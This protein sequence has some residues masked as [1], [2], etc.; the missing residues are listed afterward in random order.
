MVGYSA[1]NHPDMVDPW[2]CNSCSLL[3]HNTVCEGGKTYPRLGAPLPLWAGPQ[4]PSVCSVCYE[5]HNALDTIQSSYWRGPATYRP[6]N[7]D[8]SFDVF[9]KAAVKRI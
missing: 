7:T 1:S 2:R 4:H 3:I 6:L 5:M 9:L 8:N